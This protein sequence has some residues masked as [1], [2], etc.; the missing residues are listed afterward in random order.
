[1]PIDIVGEFLRG[2]IAHDCGKAKVRVGNRGDGGYVVLEELCS[3]T[4]EVYS[5]GIGDDVG[6]ELDFVRRWP[7][8]EVYL[9]DPNIDAPPATHRNFHFS[10]TGIGSRYGTRVDPKWGS[11]LKMDIEYGEWDALMLSLPPAVLAKFSQIIVELHIMH[12][13]PPKDLFPYW[14]DFYGRVVGKVNEELFFK[15]RCAMNNLT[16][17]F[18]CF[19]IHAN[20]SLGRITVGG[21]TFPPLL[22]LSMVN[23]NIIDGCT[24][25]SG[26]FPVQGLDWPNKSDRP[27][28]ENYYP[29]GGER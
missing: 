26:P 3:I 12:V 19:H 23:K 11:L 5:F 8:T 9:F 15:Y 24:L 4:P 16:A 14:K 28:I 21:H 7:T 10:K 25:P 18:L 2:I 13:E 27:D 1:M 20:N 6:F 22:E 17:S 29:M